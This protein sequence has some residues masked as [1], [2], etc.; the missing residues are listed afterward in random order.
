ML[1][2]IAVILLILL[3]LGVQSCASAA[4]SLKS[5]VDSY[6]GYEFLYPNSWVQVKVANG[7]DV[8][9]HDLIEETENGSVIVSPIPDNKSLRELGTPT[10][11]GYRLS[12][13]AI[14]PPESGRE[15]ELINAEA[16]DVNGETYY[17]LEY[18]VKFPNQLRHNVASVVARRGELFTFNVST[19]E[20]RWE[21]TKELLYRVVKSFSV[22]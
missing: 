22:Y 8:V 5:Y 19:T 4:S 3:S 10:E 21:K 7:P 20:R 11:V 12:K 18:A 9:L 13:N 1:K 6:D 14:A 17:L 2:R 15:A 16:R